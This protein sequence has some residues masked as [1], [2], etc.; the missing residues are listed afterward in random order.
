[1]LQVHA[2]ARNRKFNTPGVGLISAP[3]DIAAAGFWLP[4]TAGELLR[5]LSGLQTGH[6][7]ELSRL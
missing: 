5:M 7:E 6:S 4:V 1:M 3:P 2:K